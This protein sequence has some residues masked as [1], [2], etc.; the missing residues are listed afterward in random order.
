[1]AE[2][3][4]NL[5]TGDN[6]EQR[7]LEVLSEVGGSVKI[8]QL[9]KKCQAPKKILNSILYRLKKEGKVSSTA[10]ATWCL[11]GSASA[12][13]VPAVPEDPTAQPSLEDRIF[14]FLEANGPCRAL[15]IA[16]ALGMNTA[17][18]V[19]PDLYK[20]RSRHLLS[21]NGQAW[22]IYDSSQKGQRL[23]DSGMRQERAAII[24][25]QNP[26]NMIC[27][28]GANNH[29]SISESEAI[30]IGHGNTM[31]RQIA[32]TQRGPS[33]QHPL[34]LPAP[35]DPSSQNT[36]PGAWGAQH[37]HMEKSLLRRVQLGHGNEMSLPR[38]PV[39]HPAEEHP[40]GSFTGSPPVSATSADAGTSFHMQTPEPGPH[41]EGGTAQK[42]HI[43][44]SWLE[45]ATIGNSNKMTIRIA[46]QGGAGESGN[47]EEP[48]G[49]TD[50]SSKASPYGSCSHTPSSS[51]LLAPE[52]RTMTLGDSSPQTTEPV[53]T[54]EED[55]APDTE[56]R[57]T[58]E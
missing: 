17:K 29:I 23:V 8:G 20:M 10:A 41:P 13:E 47:S 42:V 5:S 31:L 48:K 53:L 28:Q 34:L 52:L 18:E 46:S 38:D 56:D 33:P 12:D 49:D 24:Y 21:Y 51:T 16:K 57:K 44:S 54:E 22:M 58:Q 35:D 7:I 19:N 39:Q 1:M 6:L 43:K 50:S 27:Q 26:I 55:G 3:A 15:H 30:Q 14:R 45:D 11:G 25:Q 32:C 2:A 4:A 40:A 36:P 37:I 9:V